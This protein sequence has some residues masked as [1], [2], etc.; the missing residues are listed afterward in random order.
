MAF[1]LPQAFY[2]PED[3]GTPPA[4]ETPPAAAA[5]PAS[6]EAPAAP[7]AAET[8][9]ASVEAAAA[10]PEAKPE[11]TPS[12]L[13]I[14]DAAKREGAPK[15]ADTPPPTD[16]GAKPEK[17][18]EGQPE[19]AKPE[20]VKAK[21]EG[22]TD[23]AK[24]ALA[25]Q[26]PAPP[27]YDAYKMPENFQAD[28]KLIGDFNGMLGEFEL[29]TKAD[30]A[31]TQGFAQK[32]VDF[33]A[34]QVQRVIQDRDQYQRDVWNRLN[35]TRIN[36]LKSDPELG[37][38]R[39]ETTLG[40]A[41]YVLESMVGLKPTEVQELL[42]VWDNG[43]VSNHRLTI[44]ALNHLYERLREPAPVPPNPPSAKGQGQRNWYA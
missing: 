27:V 25:E 33:H 17:P 32:L 38:N 2:S 22:E 9:P 24:E 14:A 7:P 23:A 20:E 39:V 26:P 35:E 15:A 6:A 8:P 21:P 31:Q 19:A 16:A 44:K 5:P 41:K 43:G 42:A 3:G 18:A 1:R 10:A 30:H 4:A 28:E 36:E 13:A 37:G 12:L 11:S 40:N 29:A 34:Q